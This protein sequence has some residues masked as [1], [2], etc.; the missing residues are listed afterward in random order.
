[1]SVL[2]GKCVLSG[3]MA[4]RAGGPPDCPVYAAAERQLS[5]NRVWADSK[6]READNARRE[7]EAT[8]RRVEKERDKNFASMQED[9]EK[10]I[11]KLN[12]QIENLTKENN[13]LHESL[14]KKR[15]KMIKERDTARGERNARDRRIK[16]LEDENDR[17]RAQN[18]QYQKLFSQL[19]SSYEQ[20]TKSSENGAAAAA[21]AGS[22]VA[23]ADGS[24]GGTTEVVH[25][26][27]QGITEVGNDG[28]SIDGTG[29]D[30][31]ATNA[32]ED[33][34][35]ELSLEE[36]KKRYA[37]L[38]DSGEAST[39]EAEHW[40]QMTLKLMRELHRN[41]ENSS[42]PS[43]KTN[44][45]GKVHSNR[46]KTDRKE[47]AQPKHPPH[48]FKEL[49]ATMEEILLEA[50]SEI[51]E[52]S[53]WYPTK[54]I[55]KKMVGIK[56][57]V[58]VQPYSAV[59][60]R[61]RKTKRKWHAPFPPNCQNAQN[62]DSSV[63]ALIFYLRNQMRVSEQNI[64]D[65]FDQVSCHQLRPSRGMI[66]KI[67]RQFADRTTVEQTSIFSQLCASDILYA[68]FTTVRWNG[69]L[70]NIMVCT[71]K[72]KVWYGFREHKGEAAVKGSPYEYFNGIGVH[73]HEAILIKYARYHQ[74]CLVHVLRYLLDAMEQEDKL[75]W[76]RSMRELLREMIKTRENAKDRVLTEE[77]I[78][79]FERRYDKIIETARIE[80][81]TTP[82]Q[83]YYHDGFNLYK[84]LSE[85][86]ESYLRFLR[87]PRLDFSNNISER[88]L[89]TIKRIMA[90][91]GSFRGKSFENPECLCAVLS[92][93]Y[94]YIIASETP[95]A[96][97]AK[98]FDRPAPVA[99]P[100]AKKSGTSDSL[101]NGQ[102]TAK[103]GSTAE[104]TDSGGGEA[105]TG[106]STKTKASAKKGTGSK[107]KGGTCAGGE[108]IA[109]SGT[110]ASTG[111]CAETG[112]KADTCKVAN[113]IAE[114]NAEA[115]NAAVA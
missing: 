111:A 68:D 17:L 92:V 83:K 2:K 7:A 18:K 21:V 44:F 26:E 103:A 112:A 8:L 9:H 46:D 42:I 32:P 109:C 99:R 72:D 80:Y 79:S 104:A 113:A 62:Y 98:I 108:A 84:R 94:S 102:S 95:L 14:A 47:G 55:T 114:A 29:T 101:K 100:S 88:L 87:D 4:H 13:G 39:E 76:H 65:F 66:N 115:E 36:I 48:V 69:K 64:V 105:P 40:R 10:E 70:M 106:A 11:G 74:E 3:S 97:I 49:E 93:Y 60:Y 15:K 22:A 75:T 77:Q 38:L 1:M 12:K 24:G 5:E 61:N 16:A 41:F 23:N 27:V 85:D 89:R 63:K 58:V 35:P 96:G 67:N 43:S 50:P 91:M 81:E 53:D 86:K 31:I 6:V 52:S 73:D 78:A 54:K 34:V 71:D 37:A 30:G 33:D 90:T 82:P 20:Q 56:F 59:V 45:R 110:K 107:A 25:T 19:I 28:T 57:M 51:T